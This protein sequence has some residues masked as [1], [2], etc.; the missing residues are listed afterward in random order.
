[1]LT[2]INNTDSLR[3]LSQIFSPSS[4]DKAIRANDI[5]R[6]E[7][8]VKKYVSS[9][10]TSITYKN[11]INFLYTSLEKDYRSEYFYKNR[12][13]NTLLEKYSLNTTTVLNEFK[14]G[15]SIADFILLNGT[16]RIY[17]IKTD[18]DS[19]DKLNKQLNDYK[20]F[21]DLVYIVTSS[22]YVTKILSDYSTSTIGVIEF[23]QDN[24]F[25]EY[26]KADS[27]K[28]YFSHSTIFKTLRKP[29]YLEIIGSYFGHTPKVPNTEIFKT[30]FE[31]INKIDVVEFQKIAFNILKK[32]K[33]KCPDS[34]AS[35]KTPFELKQI[36][37]TLDFTNQE[38]EHLYKFLNKPLKC[39]SP[40]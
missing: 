25:K 34:W 21:A 6:I 3:S 18:L 1:M 12:L 14:I 39:I 2:V 9:T 15:S 8:K 35:N 13:L 33:I 32:R 37:Y 4:F 30:C 28:S 20:Q 40:I 5:K 38:Y 27:N 19:L 11:L 29:E 23:T 10:S 17:E 24:K 22:K 26:K 7:R 16:A 31:L 36:C